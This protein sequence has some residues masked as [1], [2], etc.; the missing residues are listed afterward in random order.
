MKQQTVKK[1]IFVSNVLMIF[2][3][4]FLV[5]MINI[6]IIKLYWE[7]IEHR[8]QDSIALMASTSDI[9]HLLEQW[10]LHQQSFYVLI[11]IDIIVCAVIWIIVSM[12]FT[13]RLVDQIMKPIHLLEEGTQRIRKNNLSEKIN[14]Q[15]DQEFEEICETFNDMQAHILSEQEKN[16]KYE[17]ARTEMI[18][19]I[20]HDLRTPLTAIKGSIKGVLDGVVKD[21]QKEKFLQTA[22]HRTDEMDV[23]L[24]QLFYISKL[25]SGNMPLHLQQV[26]LYSWLDHY[27]EE[28]QK[29]YTDIQFSKSLE[30][31]KEKANIDL[32][33]FQRIF[34]NLLENTKKYDEKDPVCV[35]LSLKEKDNSFIIV[36]SDNGQG[37]PEDKIEYIFD[38]F[39]QVDESRNKKKG[40]GLGLYIVKS[41]IESMNGHVWA[42][43]NNGLSIYIELE[44]GDMGNE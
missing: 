28:K 34:D 22:Y 2:V 12:F 31:V 30:K 41:L 25:D 14:Y 35:Q 8:W 16:E 20:S 42:K 5:F 33:Q 32:D 19:G 17:K 26:D 40:N 39:Y 27:V 18:V 23:L 21:D 37:I 36:F 1:R 15:G 44:K 38:E 24:N 4:L 11:L 7:T 6:G 9:K 3:T 29:T 13:G 10:T 43:N